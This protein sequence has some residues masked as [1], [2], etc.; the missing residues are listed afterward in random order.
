[1]SNIKT[2]KNLMKGVFEMHGKKIN[3]IYSLKKLKNKIVSIIPK[4]SNQEIRRDL[5]KSREYLSLKI[6]KTKLRL[7]GRTNNVSSIIRR[8]VKIQKT[9]TNNVE[10][11]EKLL[12]EKNK[13]KNILM[14]NYNYTNNSFENLLKNIKNMGGNDTNSAYLSFLV[15]KEEFNSKKGEKVTINN[16]EIQRKKLKKLKEY[17]PQNKISEFSDLLKSITDKISGSKKVIKKKQI[18]NNNNMNNNTNAI[19]MLLEQEFK[20][21]NPNINRIPSSSI[22]QLKPGKYKITKNNITKL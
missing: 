12:N 18:N 19:G 16:L 2:A 8:L 10:E 4:I 14:K 17:M 15:I 6:R 11:L 5:R 13:I 9:K 3:N 1:M 20:K 22:K 7:N 21:N